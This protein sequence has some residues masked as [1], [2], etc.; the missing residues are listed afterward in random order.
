[1][2][3]T[4]GTRPADDAGRGRDE[5]AYNRDVAAEERDAAAH[6]RDV[7]AGRREARALMGSSRPTGVLTDVVR[8]AVL[9]RQQAAADR[10]C[11]ASDRR[12]AAAQRREGQSDRS[13]ALA[14]RGTALA[15]RDAGATLRGQDELDR[16]MSLADRG[17]GADERGHAQSDRGTAMTDRDAAARERE[18][19]SR[20]L[21]TGTRLRGAGTLEMEREVARAARTGQPMSLAFVDVDHLKSINDSRGHAAGDRMLVE[22]ADI[23]RS[24]LRSYDL[25][26]RYGGDEFVCVLA[27]MRQEEASAR[28]QHV[29]AELAGG[30][31]HGSV[32]VGVVDLRPD[33]TVESIVARADL[34]LYEQRRAH[35]STP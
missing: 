25:V 10:T 35:R 31:E 3:A 28:F 12:E 18:R 16:G 32:T 19:D 22:V 1:V 15:D 30:P 33:E 11:A 34:A 7:L 27:G 17:A 8:N 26:I 13:T 9:N 20:D 21:L 6:R 2:P 23:L 14:D 4:P 24:N 29:N 5:A